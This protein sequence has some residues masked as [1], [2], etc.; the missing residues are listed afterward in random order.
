MIVLDSNLYYHLHGL[1]RRSH[2]TMSTLSQHDSL[3][4]KKHDE[5]FQK[6]VEVKANLEREIL[7]R[8]I[9]ERSHLSNGLKDM[10]L[11]QVKYQSPELD[12]FNIDVQ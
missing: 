7:E 11:N 2:G 9:L 8:E 5:I 1:V 6:H 12:T 4:F 3:N 10:K